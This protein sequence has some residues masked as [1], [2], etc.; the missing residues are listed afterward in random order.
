MTLEKLQ[1]SPLDVAQDV[2]RLMN[3]RAGEKGLTL[4]CEVIYPIPDQVTTDLLRVRQVL[5]NLVGNA[6][7]FT[8]LGG[9]TLTLKYDSE[10]RQLRFSVTDTGI[11]I[12]P[13]QMERLFTPFSQA[14]ASMS[15]RYGGTGLGLS[16]SQRLARLLDGDIHVESQAG[17]G[18]MFTLFIAVELTS[19]TKLLT[20]PELTQQATPIPEI[21]VT[22]SC[23]APKLSGRILLA[24]DV[25]A[26]QKLISFLLQKNGASV[27]VVDNGRFAVENAL[28]AKRTNREYGLILMD[29]SMP[30]MDGFAA[31][32]A[33]REAGY[34]GRIIA[35]TAH[36][37]DE[38]RQRC[39]DSGFDGFATKPIQKDQLIAACLEHM[40]QS[41]SAM[42]LVPQ[43]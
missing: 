11:G 10:A 7:K 6:I 29:I 37:T 39:L 30:E 8:E 31:T 27:E 4:R 12:S 16:I 40:G 24:E 26:N 22:S 42:S 21:V 20:G 23:Q 36:A 25:P 17:I 33:L 18:S 9:V 28:A 43:S 32:A 35:L 19:N 38:D 34:Q 41:R 14:D 15:R 1:V 2:L 5:V 3:L 13:D